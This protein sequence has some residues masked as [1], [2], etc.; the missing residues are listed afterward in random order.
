MLL[1]LKMNPVAQNKTRGLLEDMK[2]A[3]CRLL[4]YSP[5]S[6][7]QRQDVDPIRWIPCG[8]YS[9]NERTIKAKSEVSCD[10]PNGQMI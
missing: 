10:R 8:T 5:G 3:V 2:A 4:P 7:S 1:Q 9:A 6:E